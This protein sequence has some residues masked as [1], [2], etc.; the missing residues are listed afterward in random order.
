MSLRK[1]P[2]IKPIFDGIESHQDD[3]ILAEFQRLGFDASGLDEMG[4]VQSQLAL[5]PL[6]ATELLSAIRRLKLYASKNPDIKKTVALVSVASANIF[7]HINQRIEAIKCLFQA[8]KLIDELY[9]YQGEVFTIMQST[10]KKLREE[11]DENIIAVLRQHKNLEQKP[12]YMRCQSLFVKLKTNLAQKPGATSETLKD[13][14]AQQLYILRYFKENPHIQPPKFVMDGSLTYVVTTQFN[15]ARLAGHIS[16]SGKDLDDIVKKMHEIF[17]PESAKQLGD[18]LVDDSTGLM[19]RFAVIEELVGARDTN[20][21]NLL[22]NIWQIYQ[23][24]PGFAEQRFH[25]IVFRSASAVMKACLSQPHH[26]QKDISDKIMPILLALLQDTSKKLAQKTSLPYLSFRSHSGLLVFLFRC[27]S[28]LDKHVYGASVIHEQAFLVAKVCPEAALRFAIM[29]LRRLKHLHGTELKRAELY[30]LKAEILFSQNRFDKAIKSLIRACQQLPKD[31]PRLESWKQLLDESQAKRIKLIETMD[32]DLYCEWQNILS[33]E[34]SVQEKIFKSRV[35]EGVG[36]A[37]DKVKNLNATIMV[38]KAALLDKSYNRT[39]RVCIHE[40]NGTQ[41]PE[42]YFPFALTP[43]SLDAAFEAGKVKFSSYLT[44]DDFMLDE[45]AFETNSAIKEELIKLLNEEIVPL[46]KGI[47][48]KDIDYTGL[49]LKWIPYHADLEKLLTAAES[50]RKS[51]K[52]IVFDKALV[53]RLISEVK[54]TS[55]QK[56]QLFDK[57]AMPLISNIMAELIN[58]KLLIDVGNNKYELVSQDLQS[59]SSLFLPDPANPDK[60]SLLASLLIARLKRIREQTKQSIDKDC[61]HLYKAIHAVQP[62]S[63][64]EDWLAEILELA[65]NFKHLSLVP[66]QL[67]SRRLTSS[68]LILND[69]VSQ[70]AEI[71]QLRP[72][73]HRK[74][75]KGI[76]IKAGLPASAAAELS[77]ELSKFLL[78]NN[79][80]ARTFQQDITRY[81]EDRFNDP[82]LDQL[83]VEYRRN[84]NM[85]CTAFKACKAQFLEKLQ[86][87]LS[88]RLLQHAL[89]ICDFICL[90]KLQEGYVCSDTDTYSDTVKLQKNSD[91]GIFNLLMLMGEARR[92]HSHKA[93]VKIKPIGTSDVST[94]PDGLSNPSLESLQSFHLNLI[95]KGCL[96]TRTLTEL[97]EHYIN[98]GSI[99]SATHPWLALQYLNKAIEIH[100]LFLSAKNFDQEKLARTHK[101]KLLDELGLKAEAFE[102]RAQIDIRTPGITR[103]SLFKPD[104]PANFQPF[105]SQLS[106]IKKDILDL[107]YQAFS[108]SFN[109]ENEEARARLQDHYAAI[110]VKLRHLL[111]QALSSFARDHVFHPGDMLIAEVHFPFADCPEKLKLQLAK[112]KLDYDMLAAQFPGIL[113]LIEAW[114]PYQIPDASSPVDC[115]AY[116]QRMVALAN[117]TKHK[118]LS[119]ATEDELRAWLKKHGEQSLFPLCY[120][121]RALSPWSF[122]EVA[123][124]DWQTSLN[125][126]SIYQRLKRTGFWDE[127]E[128]FTRLYQVSQTA[129]VNVL[130]SLKQKLQTELHKPGLPIFT[131][132]QQN[133]ILNLMIANHEHGLKHRFVN[134]RRLIAADKFINFVFDKIR[135]TVKALVMLDAA[136]DPDI[137]PWGLN[138]ERS[139][140]VTK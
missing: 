86:R 117:E 40:P 119:I 48:L 15:L 12:A 9:P 66:Q 3:K 91:A 88:P 123:G 110:V 27:C 47:A 17:K 73:Y 7:A 131:D 2:D 85:E 130:S 74:S 59:L 77:E 46:A 115:Y 45:Y 57:I 49:P 102:H 107:N 43:E 38:K 126:Y 69:E 129:D 60:K 39:M 70:A 35:D 116:L 122:T 100:N 13:A 16:S 1:Q 26:V 30:H 114:Q 135:T 67:S 24:S 127:I 87:Q 52:S 78:D 124:I 21:I 71:F 32:F 22:L 25:N 97:A 34:Y 79:Y 90:R 104:I 11:S 99:M 92:A 55:Q 95:S 31:D 120:T 53:G 76:F 80:I 18:M 10:G 82:M 98:A 101:A 103:I 134:N 36:E 96:T 111:D 136:F 23:L 105:Y 139:P 109:P 6:L 81:H 138:P 62:Y 94:K 112:M 14:L 132:F 113:R 108:L 106:H 37:P 133:E 93:R 72:T 19:L 8:A 75:F 68:G 64:S 5:H 50:Y 54:K 51:D 61:S 137:H 41:P 89:A 128:N 121:E 44:R 63:D 28:D 33:L 4:I 20:A 56:R 29:G 65:N 140:A 83:L 125:I 84:K 58:R 42:T 118:K